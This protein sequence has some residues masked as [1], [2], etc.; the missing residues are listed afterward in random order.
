MQKKMFPQD[1][2][3]KKMEKEA[4]YLGRREREK[5]GGV[6]YFSLLLTY[7]YFSLET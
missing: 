5:D 4:C 7:D 1:T 3:G 2:K 6:I